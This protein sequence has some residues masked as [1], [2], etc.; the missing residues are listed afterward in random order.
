[1]S[2]F[3]S[4]LYSLQIMCYLI[5]CTLGLRTPLVLLPW[6]AAGLSP[7]SSPSHSPRVR[8]CLKFSNSFHYVGERLLECRYS[9]VVSLG[10]GN[11]FHFHLSLSETIWGCSYSFFH[12]FIYST[13]LIVPHHGPVDMEGLCPKGTRNLVGETGMR[14]RDWQSA[15]SRPGVR[16]AVGREATTLWGTGGEGAN[17]EEASQGEVWEA[18]AADQGP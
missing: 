7:N 8:G 11:H 9:A 1:M 13:C 2:D 16:L 3:L 18:Q 17:R 4:P 6:C 14:S 15:W 12:L 10:P 5:T